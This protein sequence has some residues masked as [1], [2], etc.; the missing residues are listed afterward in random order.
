MLLFPLLTR[1][2]FS[3]ILF[4][5]YIL[6]IS[7]AF[8]ASTFMNLSKQWVREFD[9]LLMRKAHISLYFSAVLWLKLLRCWCLIPFY[10]GFLSKVDVT[11]LS[12]CLSLVSV[13][14][15]VWLS[16]EGAHCQVLFAGGLHIWLPSDG[17]HGW[18]VNRLFYVCFVLPCSFC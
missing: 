4:E 3:F 2:S 15:G 7:K 16:L 10:L 12:L 14:P 9:R 18:L 13:E 5:M 17:C 1:I 6:N 8:E 11:F